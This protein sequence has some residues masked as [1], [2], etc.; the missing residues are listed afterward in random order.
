MK[1]LSDWKANHSP[2]K[3]FTS[4]EEWRAHHERTGAVPDDILAGQREV[5]S[6]GNDKAKS[7]AGA[8]GPMQIV[9]KA[10]NLDPKVVADPATNLDIGARDM[11]KLYGQFGGDIT[12]ALRA[13]NQGAKNER[14]RAV[15]DMP[16]EAREYPGKVIQAS[17][18]Y[19]KGTRPDAPEVLAT[20]KK[21]VTPIPMEDHWYSPVVNQAK[22]LASMLGLGYNTP[23]KDTK[24]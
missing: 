18:K 24:R 4:L 13:Y 11:D 22:S 9:P 1:S 19:E 7:G 17:M 12:R 20:R 2:K 10:H 6:A 3:P 16:K 23:T 15:E 14:N 5:E 21:E 8:I